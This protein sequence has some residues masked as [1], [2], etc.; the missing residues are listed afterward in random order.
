MTQ[1]GASVIQSDGMTADGIGRNG[2]PRAGG[3]AGTALDVSD[4]QVVVGEGVALDVRPAGF[5]L[6]AVSSLIDA[7]VTIVIAIAVLWVVLWAIANAVDNGARIENAALI[8]IVLATQI[9]VLVFVPCLIET[10]TRGKSVGRYI[11]RLR[12]VRDDGGAAGFRHALIRALVGFFEFWSTSG[13][14]AMITGLV[15]A[16]SKRLGDII[17]G[18]YAQ[19]EAAPRLSPNLGPLPP[20]LERWAT[21]AD[22]ARMP[23]RSARRMRDYL[24]QAPRLEPGARLHAAGTIA[25]EIKDS[26]HPIPDVDADTFLRAVAAVRRDRE[27]A[28][29]ELRR[30]RL[31]RVEPILEQ[32]PHG[33]PQ[34]G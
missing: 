24:I 20:G 26:V 10:I 15:N 30:A 23:D 9:A 19:N 13:G 14:I 7:V 27:W 22:V 5:L 25:R 8:A 33:F 12:I 6:R 31:A 28:A 1:A 34:R 18:T 21:I 16:R 4:E 17:A 29:I 3:V 2:A 11:M 32:L